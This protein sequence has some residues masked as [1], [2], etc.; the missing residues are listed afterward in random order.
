MRVLVTGARGFVGSHILRDFTAAGHE[1]WS[2]IHVTEQ[3]CR[4]PYERAADISD[5]AAVE[6][7]VRELRP[8]ACLH[9]AGIAFVPLGWTQPDLVFNVNVQGTINVLEALR[10][11][12]PSARMLAVSSS[13][14]Y[15]NQP[16][17]RPVREDDTPRPDSPYGVSKLAADL[18][19]L[20][21]ARR[22][23][24]QTM[25]ARPCNHIGPGQNPDFAVPSFAR[26]VAAIAAGQAEPVMRVGNL[27]SLRE[28]MDV[29]DVAAAY[30]LLLERGVPGRA[31]NVANGGCIRVGL[32]L[33]TLCTLADIAPRIEVDPDKFRPTDA[34]P[35][36]DASRL[37]ADTGWHPAYTLEHT[38]ADVLATCT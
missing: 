2:L 27:D 38:L 22:Y 11:H 23:G 8:E 3:P 6:A 4:T 21:Y 1:V 17:E 12:A 10:R 33:E 36:L 35:P 34:Q 20:L 9:L 26:Q 7:I 18:T 32:L 14:I 5:T 31:Y 25:T 37:R 13:Q 29:R 19:T 30:R 16:T 28:F 15:G 24:L